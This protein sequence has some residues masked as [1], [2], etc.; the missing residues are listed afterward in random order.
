MWIAA[1]NI[2]LLGEMWLSLGEEVQEVGDL[3]RITTPSD[4]FPRLPSH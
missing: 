1:L 4:T 2:L 3:G